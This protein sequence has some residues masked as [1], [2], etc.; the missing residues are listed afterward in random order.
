MKPDGHE[1]DS[2]DWDFV[3]H[4]RCHSSVPDGAHAGARVEA[5]ERNKGGEVVVNAQEIGVY[6]EEAAT[7][8]RDRQ[9]AA[10]LLAAA[11]LLDAVTS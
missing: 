3:T 7:A 2:T 8:D 9:Y 1:Y 5:L 6:V 10:D 4:V 11:D